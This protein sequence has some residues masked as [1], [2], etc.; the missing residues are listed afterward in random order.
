MSKGALYIIFLLVFKVS[1][2]MVDDPT[3]KPYKEL[4]ERDSGV[5]VPELLTITFSSSTKFAGSCKFL[6]YVIQINPR[7]WYNYDTIQRL[8]LVYHELSHCT[9][10][11]LKHNDKLLEDGCQASIMHSKLNNS[12]CLKKHWKKYIAEF[13]LDKR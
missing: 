5:K 11:R 4:F 6:P 1:D 12:K 2:F 10:F 9:C 3:F 13:C 7:I 8:G